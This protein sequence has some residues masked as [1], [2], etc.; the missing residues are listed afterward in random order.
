MAAWREHIATLTRVPTSL[1]GARPSTPSASA[2][3]GTDLTVGLIPGHRWLTAPRRR[4][5]ACPHV[6]NMPTEEVYTTPDRRRADGVVRSTL[7]LALGGTIVRDLELRFE[8]GRA[9]DVRATTGAD[10]VRESM[11]TDPGA[12]SLGEVALVDGDSRVRKTGH[13]LP[14]HAVRRERDVAHR[15]RP[16]HPRRA[17]ARRR[18]ARRDA[19]EELGYNDSLVHTDFMV[20]G[21][22]VE[23]FG[24][25]P[26]GAEVPIIRDDAW[27]LD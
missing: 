16:G 22:E 13:R 10:A 4:S 6:V 23:V 3:P 12:A 27:V 20:G 24:V 21:P 19:L 17:P 18:P 11:A 14:R 8:G 2:G 5:A 7:P 25:E 1:D 15:L 9:V 26:G